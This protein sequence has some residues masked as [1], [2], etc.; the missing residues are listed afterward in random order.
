MDLSQISN[1]YSEIS[2]FNFICNKNIRAGIM[3]DSLG[4]VVKKKNKKKPK[5]TNCF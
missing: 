3:A 5:A 1:F 2:Y 4:S